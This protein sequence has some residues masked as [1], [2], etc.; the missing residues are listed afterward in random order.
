[1]LS[2]MTPDMLIKALDKT[3]VLPADIRAKF[4][5]ID[6]L[7]DTA[8]QNILLDPKNG[9]LSIFVK[10]AS[11]KVFIKAMYEKEHLWH[12][13]EVKERILEL[14]AKIS[15]EKSKKAKLEQMA[16]SISTAGDTR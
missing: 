6:P 2:H 11:D 8:L 12:L 14:F 3:V 7:E 16:K 4:A 9:L 15:A 1:M 10:R 13:P 5:S